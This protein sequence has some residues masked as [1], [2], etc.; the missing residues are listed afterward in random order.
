MYNTFVVGTITPFSGSTTPDK[1]GELS[2]MVQCVGGRMPNRNVL[3]GTVAKRA[4]FEVGKT[5]LINIREQGFDKVFGPDYTFIKVMELESG[6]DIIE[7]ALKLGPPEVFIVERPEGFEEIYDRKSSAIEGLRTQRIKDGLYI[8]SYP[9]TTPNHE[10]AK[11]IIKG[12]SQ[13]PEGTEE[14]DQ[15]LFD[16]DLTEEEYNALNPG[17]RSLYDIAK[18]K[19]GKK[20]QQGQS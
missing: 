9:T 18:K 13:N 20:G 10:T 7:S 11:D 14:F 4:G 8:P 12:T 16:K 1:N 6:Q 3:S 2:V 15:S 5:Y 19:R 17:E